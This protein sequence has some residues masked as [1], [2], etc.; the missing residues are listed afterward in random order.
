MKR[1]APLALIAALALTGCVS[2]EPSAESDPAPTVK[3]VADTVDSPAPEDPKAFDPNSQAWAD[4][5]V[6]S[7]LKI[8][9]VDSVTEFVG[10]YNLVTDWGSPAQNHMT[11]VVDDRI[12]SGKTDK[13]ATLE[14]DTVGALLSLGQC[15]SN[16]D[17]VVTAINE[18]G[19][20]KASESC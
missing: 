12:S 18:S 8:N 15:D 19:T 1:F 7:W 9:E 14:L 4:S 11:L 17:L 10:P 6:K 3:P 5:L 20:L 16:P 13:E 2:A